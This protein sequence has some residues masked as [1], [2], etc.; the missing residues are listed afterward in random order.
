MTTPAIRFKRV[1]IEKIFGPGSHDIEIDFRLDER[2]TI[3]HGRNG[4]GKTVTLQL[5]D[6][7]R[8]G[9]Y[10]E[11]LKYP[12]NRC[13]I[14]RTDGVSAELRVTRETREWPPLGKISTPVITYS[15]AMPSAAP[16]QGKVFPVPRM[17]PSWFENPRRRPRDYPWSEADWVWPWDKKYSGRIGNSLWISVS[18]TPTSIPESIKGEP[19]PLRDFRDQLPRIKLILTDRLFIRSGANHRDDE[20]DALRE[21]A[22]PQLMVE[23]LSAVIRDSVRMADEKYRLQS[24][25]LDSSLPQRLF[26]PHS[27]SLDS[28]TLQG[29][30]EALAEKEAKLTALGLL[31]EAPGRTDVAR[32]TQDQLNTFSVILDDQEEKLRAFDHV[33]DRAERILASLNRKFAPKKVRLDVETGYQ[34]MTADGRPLP[35][36]CLSSGEQHELVLLHELLFDVAAGSLILID[37]PELSLHVTWQEALIEDLIGIAEVADLDFVLATHSPEIIGDHVK[38]M[39]RLGDPA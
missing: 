19:D 32:L 10:Q 26:R 6:A 36:N 27:K 8:N 2:V 33:A 38:L 3:L 39:V 15:I 16:K 5:L 29:R 14:E 13:V 31:K 7:L 17:R 21:E 20:D 25:K 30:S 9:K 35:L 18:D 12:L 11:L 28:T 4:S 37:E 24:Y 1:L 22:A 34:V 23:H